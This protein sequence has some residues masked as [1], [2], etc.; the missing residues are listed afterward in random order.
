MTRTALV[1]GGGGALGIS[2]E[3]GVLAG[4]QRSG[5]DVTG[6]DLLVGTSAGSVVASQIAQ[7]HTLDSLVARHLEARPDGIEANME[8]DVQNLMTIFQRWAALPE[9]TEAACAEIGAMA[10]ASMTV[11][12]D[13]W[14]ASFEDLVDPDWPERDLLLTTVDAVTGVFRA[15]SRNDGIDIRRAVASS[16][17]VPGMFPCVEFGGRRYQDGGVRSG[18]SADLARDYDAVLIVAPIGSRGDSIDPLLGRLTRAEAE[19]LA[20]AGVDVELVFPDAQSLE[21]MGFNRMDGTRR[22]VTIEAGITQ[23]RELAVRLEAAWSKTPA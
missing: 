11:S 18:T 3:T 2:W 19:A 22:P 10:L 14:I 8:F 16:C 1:L 12:E 13:R 23:G 20:A 21:A 15:W 6:A 17:A 7:G 5:V 9:V 4:L